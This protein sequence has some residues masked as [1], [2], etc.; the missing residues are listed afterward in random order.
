MDKRSIVLHCDKKPLSVR[1]VSGR[2]RHFFRKYRQYS[3]SRCQTQHLWCC[4]AELADSICVGPVAVL[5][6]WRQPDRTG[7]DDV[8]LQRLTLPSIRDA[9][10]H[11]LIELWGSTDRCCPATVTLITLAIDL[12]HQNRRTATRCISVA[13]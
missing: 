5:L 7:P 4:V 2:T 1:I 3:I 9:A 6:E 13:S 11:A 12:H 10:A 8:L